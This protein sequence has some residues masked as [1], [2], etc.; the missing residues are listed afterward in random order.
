MKKT[1]VIIVGVLVVLAGIMIYNLAREVHDPVK[2]TLTPAEAGQLELHTQLEKVKQDESQ[3]EK[4]NWNAE[5]QLR[6]LI[7]GHEQRIEKLTGNNAAKEILA[8][9]RDSITRLEKRITDLEAQKL[10]EEQKKELEQEQA[11]QQEQSTPEQ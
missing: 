7:K 2:V 9:D 4:Q 5:A 8:Y 3:V 1:I 10:A 11:H 6:N